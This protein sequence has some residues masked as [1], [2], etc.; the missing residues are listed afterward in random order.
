MFYDFRNLNALLLL[1]CG[2]CMAAG[3]LA[4]W[5]VPI[6]WGWIK[7]FIHQITG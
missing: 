1:I 6:L 7:P 5:L 4:V 3:A 2:C